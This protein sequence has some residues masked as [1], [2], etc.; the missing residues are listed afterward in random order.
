M[1]KTMGMTTQKSLLLSKIL[2]I[3]TLCVVSQIAVGE[4]NASNPL[5]KVK[6]R[7]FAGCRVA[8]GLDWAVDL[9]DEDKGTGS[10]SDTPGPFVGLAL[11]LVGR[12]RNR[13][14]I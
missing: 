1:M 4:E 9:G 10:G 14:E 6:N 5:A 3:S 12:T 11:A 8:V 7:S 13:P 2:I